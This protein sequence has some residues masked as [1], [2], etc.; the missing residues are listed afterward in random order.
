MGANIMATSSP[1]VGRKFHCEA[2]LPAGGSDHDVT[3]TSILW[4]SNIGTSPSSSMLFPRCGRRT[5]TNGSPPPF[6]AAPSPS[7]TSMSPQWPH[8]MWASTSL[9]RNGPRWGCVKLANYLTGEEHPFTSFFKYDFDGHRYG[10]FAHLQIF[11]KWFLSQ[12]QNHWIIRAFVDEWVDLVSDSSTTTDSIIDDESGSIIT[13]HRK[14]WLGSNYSQNG[15]T[16]SV[17]S[18][19][20]VR[21]NCACVH[22]CCFLGGVVN[23]FFFF[24]GSIYIRV[25]K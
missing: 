3:T 2:M 7:T 23:V 11:K 16:V 18:V 10:V 17:E 9:G 4:Y 14:W 6:R 8:R 20:F 25:C 19:R 22:D 5:W 13:L 12:N 21:I 15:R 24:Q 1:V